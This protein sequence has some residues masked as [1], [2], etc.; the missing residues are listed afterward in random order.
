M[1][2]P[3][4]YLFSSPN[5]ETVS[6]KK[7]TNSILYVCQ[8][9]HHPCPA[10]AFG[11]LGSKQAAAPGWRQG[12]PGKLQMIAETIEFAGDPARKWHSTI[13]VPTAYRRGSADALI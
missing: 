4:H 8:V 2:A 12:Q 3:L 7:T 1:A 9:P 11:G 5:D 6:A 10:A 13:G